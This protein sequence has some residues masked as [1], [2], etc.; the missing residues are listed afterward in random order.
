[1]KTKR[2]YFVVNCTKAE[3]KRL[4]EISDFEGCETLAQFMRKFV[5]NIIT[6]YEKK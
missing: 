2:I 6:A 3:K 5:R 4:K 1:M